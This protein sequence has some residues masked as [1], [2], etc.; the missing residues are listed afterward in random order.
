VAYPE[1]NREQKQRDDEQHISARAE[2]VRAK[3]P[4]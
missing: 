4:E 2:S 1:F 3:N